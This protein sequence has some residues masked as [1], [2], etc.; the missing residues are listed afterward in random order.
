MQDRAAIEQRPAATHR[1]DASQIRLA[2]LR[3]RTGRARGSCP[4]GA[5]NSWGARPSPAGKVE[6]GRRAAAAL[7]GEANAEWLGAVIDRYGWPGWAAV[8]TDGSRAAW[9]IAQHGPPARQCRVVPL[10]AAAV[11][12]AD[13]DPVCLAYLIDRVLLSDGGAQLFGTQ[14]E[15]RPGRGLVRR[16]VDHPDRVVDRLRQLGVDAVP[17]RDTPSPGHLDLP[18]PA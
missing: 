9:S 1:G 10:V 4:S 3:V 2:P 8:G 13:A 7:A 18:D 6:T 12:T 14:Y 16:P 15:H 5:R 17:G 11:V